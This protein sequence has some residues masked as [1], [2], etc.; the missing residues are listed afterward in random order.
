MKKVRATLT[1]LGLV[2]ILTVAA[3]NCRAQRNLFGYVASYTCT[4]STCYQTE[5]STGYFFVQM[6]IRGILLNY[7]HQNS[8]GKS[9]SVI[10]SSLGC[11]IAAKI[12]ATGSEVYDMTYGYGVAVVGDGSQLGV[13]L[14]SRSSSVWYNRTLTL[15]DAMT[16]CA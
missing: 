1:L 14:I 10:I 11:T 5:T 8:K 16:P 4:P 3:P 13:P 7:Q 2:T 15:G 6:G 12:E 9:T